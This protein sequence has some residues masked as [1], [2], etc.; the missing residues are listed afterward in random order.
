MLNRVLLRV[1]AAVALPLLVACKANG[2]RN[3]APDSFDY[4]QAVTRSFQEQMLLNLV[5]LRYDEVPTFLTVNSVL[6]Q[7]VYAGRVGI[8]ANTGDLNGFA[9]W[10]VV[11]SASATYIERPTITYG[12]LT[13]Q[14]FAQQ[15][16]SPIP[17]DLLFSL[18]QSGWPAQQL[19]VMSLERLNGIG[20]TPFT[21]S[22]STLADPGSTNFER[23]VELLLLI[24]AREGVEMRRQDAEAVLV[25][26][27]NADAETLAFMDELRKLLDLKDGVWR[28]R[29]TDR[30]VDRGDDEITLRMRSI[31]ALMAFLARGI[32]VPEAHAA[33][34]RVRR[35]RAGPT[36]PLQ[37][38]SS[39][40][41]PG[42]AFVAVRYEGHWFSVARD[43]QKSRQAFGLLSYLF[44]L[45]APQTPN[46]APIVTVPTG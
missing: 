1:V 26:D 37:V 29:V 5:R 10:G 40:E 13:G 9:T 20:N 45:Q 15:L 27:Q 7:Y 28:F 42:D 6:T 33:E 22:P 43:D 44:Q 41:R 16:L 34:E 31:L 35:L 46:A 11:G 21:D 30:V 38:H 24:A 12:P 18:I 17:S 8:G 14:D 3:L 39:R 32:E 2:P 36:V 25:F 4:N 19:L 23:V